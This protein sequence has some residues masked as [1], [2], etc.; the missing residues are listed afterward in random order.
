MYAVASILI[1]GEDNRVL[2]QYVQLAGTGRRCDTW[3]WSPARYSRRSQSGAGT[4]GIEYSDLQIR[5]LIHLVQSLERSGAFLG[6]LG[7]FAL[8]CLTLSSPSLT[9]VLLLLQS[10]LFLPVRL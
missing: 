4:Q 7:R 1:C 6:L 9:R 5:K 8:S 2:L 10:D 3:P